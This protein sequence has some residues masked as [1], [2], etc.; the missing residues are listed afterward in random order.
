[1]ILIGNSNIDCF[2]RLHIE[3]PAGREPVQVQWVGA[4]KI[5]HF[6][7]SNPIGEKVRLICKSDKGWRFLSIG[8]HDI[9]QLFHHASQGSFQAGFQP[10]IQKYEAVFGELAKHGKFAWLVFPQPLQSVVLANLPD[11]EKLAIA[12]LFNKTLSKFC[13]EKRIPVINPLEGLLSAE[14]LPLPGFLQKDGLHLNEKGAALYLKDISQ[15]TRIE[16]LVK[17]RMHVFEPRSENE[18]FC[19]LLL[20]NLD[21]S[22]ERTPGIAELSEVL[23]KFMQERCHARGLDQEMGVNTGLASTGLFDSLDLVELYTTA[24][25]YM[26]LEMDFDVNLRELDTIDCIVRFIFE[27]HKLVPTMENHP[28]YADFLCSLSSD[29]DQPSTRREVLA[30]EARI[31]FLSPQKF[32]LFVESFGV[33]SE[34]NLGRY[35]FPSFWMSLVWA[36][37]REF[38]QAMRLLKLAADPKCIFP[39][40]DSKLHHYWESWRAQGAK[41]IWDEKVNASFVLRNKLSQSA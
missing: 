34:G 13:A 1:M 27:A 36:K 6:F 31:G 9:F 24:S 30:A 40:S 8:T 33:A 4:L 12:K 19:S 17:E 3:I 25:E 21:L 14:S 11:K 35:G 15:L 26:R 2:N 32:T 7:Q 29:F 5:D 20:N 23:V 10:M 38:S 39:I 22:P 16:L 41:E 18:S 37:R 28:V